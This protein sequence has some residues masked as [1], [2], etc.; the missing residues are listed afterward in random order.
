MSYH[1]FIMFDRCVLLGLPVAV[2]IVHHHIASLGS[3]RNGNINKL[4][5][6]M[7]SFVFIFAIITLELSIE[8][9]RKIHSP[10]PISSP[11]FCNGFADEVCVS[12]SLGITHF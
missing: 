3:W 10:D 6:K 9:N 5:T 1:F 8:S 7:K 12:F 11:V 4:N 2:F